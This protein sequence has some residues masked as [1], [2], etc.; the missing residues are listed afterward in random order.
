MDKLR[1][2]F[3]IIMA[4]RYKKRIILANLAG[5]VVVMA[6]HAVKEVLEL[7][8]WNRHMDELD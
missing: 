2:V 8:E 1:F 5:V 7:R 4:R 6:Y 3:D